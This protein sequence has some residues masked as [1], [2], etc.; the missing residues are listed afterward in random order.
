MKGRPDVDISTSFRA[1]ELRFGKVPKTKKT[2]EGA[3]GEDHEDEVVREN[4]PEE[5]E[6]GV[7]YRDAGARWDVRMRVIHP[8]DPVPAEDPDDDA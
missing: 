8:E 5:V 4:L 6:P 7:T 1:E 3:P 2:F